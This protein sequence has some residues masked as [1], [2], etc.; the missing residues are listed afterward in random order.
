MTLSLT[1]ENHEKVW[2]HEDYLQLPEDGN[3]YEIIEGVL[4]VSQAT[5]E[6][7]DHYESPDFPGLQLNLSQLFDDVPGEEE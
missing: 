2:A 7:G 6:R 5:L 4:Y 3:R 1:Q